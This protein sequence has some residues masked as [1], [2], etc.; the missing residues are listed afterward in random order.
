[1]DILELAKV[2]AGHSDRVLAL[3]ALIVIFILWR[4]D[5]TKYE[6]RDNERA[7]QIEALHTRSEERDAQ[8]TALV[9]ET[10][11]SLTRVTDLL[12]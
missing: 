9:R 5:I 11:A 10:V 6:Q 2:L 8:Y 1:M 3:A 12:K 7:E 4:K